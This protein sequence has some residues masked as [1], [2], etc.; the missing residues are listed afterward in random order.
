MVARTQITTIIAAVTPA[1]TAFVLSLEVESPPTVTLT[2]AEK[3]PGPSCV[4]ACT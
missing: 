3:L 1:T 2:G 4:T